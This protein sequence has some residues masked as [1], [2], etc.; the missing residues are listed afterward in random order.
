MNSS[1]TSSPGSDRRKSYQAVIGCLALLG[2]HYFLGLSATLNKCNAFDEI[3]HL[4]GGYSYNRF[5]DFRLQ[6]ENGML[7]QRW[8]ALPLMFSNIAFVPLDHYTWRDCGAD[9]VGHYLLFENGNDPSYILFVGRAMNGLWSVA[10]GLLLFVWS[11][12]LSGKYAA[13]LTL[14]LWTFSPA[15]LSHGFVATSDAAAAF[16]F[17]ASMGALWGTLHR[18]TWLRLSACC[19]A[20]AGL[21]MSK[22]SAPLVIPVGLMVGTVRLISGDSWKVSLFG[23]RIVQGRLHRLLLMAGLAVLLVASTWSA[24]WVG[25]AGRYAMF[26]RAVSED[27]IIEEKDSTDSLLKKPNIINSIV[28]V[29]LERHWLPEAYLYGFAYTRAYSDNRNAF[30]L[31]EF[32]LSG[33]R[34]FFPYCELVKTPT[35]TLLLVLFA[36]A[37]IMA[38]CLK[39]PKEGTWDGLRAGLYA[40]T[41][42]WALFFVY[43]GAAICSHLNIGHRHLLPVE[44]PLLM[45]AGCA[46]WWWPVRLVS[47]SSSGKRKERSKSNA[48]DSSFASLAWK[49]KVPALLVA[50]CTCTT[51]FA[52]LA[53]WPNYLAFFNWPSGGPSQAWKKLND[54]SLD[55]GQELPSLKRWLEKEKSRSLQGTPFYLSYFGSSYPKYYGIDATLL[56]GFFDR[57]PLDV[58]VPLLPGVYCISA[59]MLQGNYLSFPVP[60]TAEYD[61]EYR[62]M[63]VLEHAA[64]DP[65]L[66]AEWQRISLPERKSWMQGFRKYDEAR[67]MRLANTLRRRAPDDHVNYGILIYRVSA[68]ELS[69][70]LD[71]S[72][73]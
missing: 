19:A 39:K 72:F 61:R 57:R 6:P 26:N 67:F 52:A 3:L 58:T 60:W 63:Q 20:M 73:D 16:L 44:G 47:S 28:R 53:S 18:L 12:R 56:P 5:N 24:I 29:A 21:F 14:V 71:G 51:I 66:A 15:F 10:L 22:Y 32:G 13:W 1:K 2:L 25:Y 49:E 31:G 70:A 46:A 37:A 65:Q 41:P 45:F 48:H 35:G 42:L 9:T 55:W 36:G 23:E 68:D 4:A 30:F 69:R 38:R 17:I 11:Y 64:S 62:K 59:T 34:T 54:S 50:G 27:G 8:M 7:P 43:W 33:W 40:T